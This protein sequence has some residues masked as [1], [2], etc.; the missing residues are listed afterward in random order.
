M[1]IPNPFKRID[2]QSL[3][4]RLSLPG[5]ASVSWTATFKNADKLAAWELYVEMSTTVLTQPLGDNDGDEQSAL[6]SLYSIFET[7]REVLRRYGPPSYEC[8][9]VSITMLNRAIRPFTAKPQSTEK[10]SVSVS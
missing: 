8:S 10:M 3:V 1:R 6:S 7:T 2:S 4:V 9:K 5:A